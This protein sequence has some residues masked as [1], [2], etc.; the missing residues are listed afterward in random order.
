MA[1]SG[2]WVNYAIPG[3]VI[4]AILTARSV[5]RA[6]NEARLARSLI[7]MGVAAVA[8]L[9]FE[10]SNEFRTFH[11]IR[12][13]RLSAELVLYNLKERKSALY[14]AGAP[15]KNRVCGSTDLVFDDW[16][17][18]VF[19]SLHLAEPRSSWLASTLTGGSV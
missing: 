16:L 5:S 17:Y 8:L 4:A 2:V 18:P 7:P 10:L 11:H 9:G 3:I 1:S 12:A 13:E 14:F 6:C 15:G 19:E